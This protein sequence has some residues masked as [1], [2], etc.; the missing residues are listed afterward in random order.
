MNYFGEILK[1][2]DIYG[3]KI[4]LLYRGEDAFRT[5][6]G[7]LLTVA[8]YVLILIQMVN[9]LTDFLEHT[10]QTERFTSV[11]VDLNNHGPVNLFDNLFK[12]VL[13]T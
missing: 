7:G 10:A 9:L 1:R 2:Q 13:A 8:T 12:I 4:S 11:K 5:K 6:F 3:H